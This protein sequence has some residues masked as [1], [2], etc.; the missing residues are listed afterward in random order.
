M[1]LV[2]KVIRLC[3]LRTSAQTHLKLLT[4]GSP[5]QR[6]I[7]ALQMTRWG[8]VSFLLLFICITGITP[9][10]LSISNCEPCGNENV[11]EKK[12]KKEKV[13]EAPHSW[14]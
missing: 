10:I 14:K 2:G 7:F 4:A 8:R 5:H 13:V 1:G 12:N 11:E 9:L 3:S 6:V